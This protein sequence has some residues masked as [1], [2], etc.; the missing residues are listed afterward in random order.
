MLCPYHTSSML[1]ALL[2]ASEFVCR[3]DIAGERQGLGSAMSAGTAA[4]LVTTTGGSIGEAVR[5]R[6]IAGAAG[7]PRHH[8]RPDRSY[9][10]RKP[11]GPRPF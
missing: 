1:S 2:Y 4:A 9:V 10:R 5:A 3:I 8:R 11:A 7:S 6:S